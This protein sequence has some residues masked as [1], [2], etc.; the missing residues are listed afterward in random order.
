MPGRRVCSSALRLPRQLSYL[1]ICCFGSL[2]GRRAGAG[3]QD[4]SV[5]VTPACASPGGN[6]SP[7]AGPALAEPEKVQVPRWAVQR[8]RPNSKEHR[9]LQHELVGMLRLTQPVQ[10]PFNR[11]PVQQQVVVL[12]C[13]ASPVQQPLANGLSNAFF[14]G[15][16]ASV[17]RYGR[18]MLPTRQTFA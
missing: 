10:Q 6:E 1:A 4:E 12:T 9:P 7:P 15:S 18:M 2:E 3:P 17:S 13:L 8:P 16:H 11:I 5:S 14:G